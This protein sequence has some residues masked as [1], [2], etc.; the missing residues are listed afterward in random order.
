MFITF[1]GTFYATF[2]HNILQFAKYS[3]IFLTH[4][5]FLKEKE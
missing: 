2:G 3:I 5:T 1:K 4:L